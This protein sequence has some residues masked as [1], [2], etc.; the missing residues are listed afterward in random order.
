MDATANIEKMRAMSRKAADCA[1]VQKYVKQTIKHV[2]HLMT[3]YFELDDKD[4]ARRLHVDDK[5]SAGQVPLGDVIDVLRG[6]GNIREDMTLLMNFA[7]SSCDLIWQLMI[8]YRMGKRDL[9]DYVNRRSLV[10]RIRAIV[11]LVGVP[12]NIIATCDYETKACAYADSSTFPSVCHLA[13][14][15]KPGA[16]PTSRI[17]SP[18]FR[19]KRAKKE[20]DTMRV[21]VADVYPPLSFRELEFMDLTLGK[22]AYTTWVTGHMYW[23]ITN[24]GNVFHSIFKAFKRDMIC[25]PSANTDTAL[26]IFWLFQPFHLERSVLA[27]I[28]WMCNPPDHS[29]AEI[30]IASK[31]YGLDYVLNI[32]EYTYTQQL[33]D[34]FGGNVR[35]TLDPGQHKQTKCDFNNNASDTALPKD[36]P[37]RKTVGRRQYVLGRQS[38]I[39]ATGYY[40]FAKQTKRIVAL[41]VAFYEPDAKKL[42]SET[43]WSPHLND[44]FIQCAA[45]LDEK[46]PIRLLLSRAD[47]DHVLKNKPLPDKTRIADTE[48]PIAKVS[49]FHPWAKAQSI[50][51]LS[52]LLSLKFRVYL[53]RKSM[54]DHAICFV[55]KHMDLDKKKYMDITPKIKMGLKQRVLVTQNDYHFGFVYPPPV[56]KN[57]GFEIIT[58]HHG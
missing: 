20:S 37:G 49:V 22:D 2:H 21:P 50:T 15:N 28:A 52:Q 54:G 27:C 16:V 55:T 47:L 4:I 32:D 45:R 12:F 3:R 56:V 17:L 53:H 7:K 34:T 8:E 26:D 24:N 40:D 43:W 48:F 42:D 44:R 6:H 35:M 1:Q 9:P 23:E 14:F 30:L 18:S 57:D 58:R 13:S 36:M 51:E 39:K 19:D 25:G 46:F 38:I 29:V 33:I 41:D 31:P 10:A 5:G 11:Q